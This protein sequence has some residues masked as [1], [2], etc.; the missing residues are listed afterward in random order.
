MGKQSLNSH[1]TEAKTNKKP[2]QFRSYSMEIMKN[3]RHLPLLV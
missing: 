3:V 2:K 1:E